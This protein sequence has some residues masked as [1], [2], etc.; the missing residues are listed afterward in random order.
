MRSD[1]ERENELAEAHKSNVMNNEGVWHNV[2]PLSVC[3]RP[4]NVGSRAD[5]ALLEHARVD[6]TCPGAN[7][8]KLLL[9]QGQQ[10]YGQTGNNLIEM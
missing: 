6:K 2:E 4:T 7:S 8:N 5:L 3:G 10:T 1:K 9:L